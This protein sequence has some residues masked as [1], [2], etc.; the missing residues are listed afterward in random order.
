M[1]AGAVWLDT[2]DPI[3]YW[4]RM[5][6]M[7]RGFITSVKKQ[8]VNDFRKENRALFAAVGDVKHPIEFRDA[9]IAQ[10]VKHYDMTPSYK[11]TY[12]GIV[13]VFAERVYD[14][15]TGAKR[16]KADPKLLDAWLAAALDWVELQGGELIAAVEGYS[17]KYVVAWVSK[18]TSQAIEEGWAL[19]QLK[20]AVMA[21]FDG[22]AEFRA[23]RIARTEVMRAASLGGNVAANT[24]DLKL[25][26]E[27]LIGIPGMGDRHAVHYPG[28]DGQ[29]RE[30]EEYYDVGGYAALYPLDAMLPAS[31]SVNCVCSEYY[32]P[33]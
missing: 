28:L 10:V 31:E 20:R 21:Q 7:R 22:M 23:A 17:H 29:Q 13:P 30:L 12:G 19:P 27:W 15:L 4:K 5:D 11:K 18:L 1:S 3:L 24:T 25:M 9:I 14:Q 8:W 32:I 6:R 33:K 16:Q 2:K 26:K